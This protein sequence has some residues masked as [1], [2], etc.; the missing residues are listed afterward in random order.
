MHRLLAAL[1]L[2]SPRDGISKGPIL[3]TLTALALP[4]ALSLACA[5]EP[6]LTPVYTFRAGPRRLGVYP[7]LEVSGHGLV[8]RAFQTDG[9]VRASPVAAGGVLLFGSG[10]GNFYAVEATGGRERWR[11]TAGSAILSSAAVAGDLVFFGDRANGFYAL[12]RDSG[13]LR[14]RVE[15]GE[16]RAFEWGHE[17]WDYYTS[18]PVLADGAV[19]V[20][21][22]D[23]NLYAL[24][25][26]SGEERWRYQTGGRIRSSPAA[27]DGRVYVG[28]ADGVLYAIEVETGRLAW[29]FETWGAG[30]SS[31]DFGYD[32]KTIQSSPAVADGAVF[33]GSRDGK[34]YAVDAAT[35]RERW[36]HDNGSPWVV[37]SPAVADGR[38]YVGSSDGLFVHALDAATGEEI[39]RL[40]TG[41]RVFSSPAVS[42]DRLY[43]GHHGRRLLSIER[44]SGELAWEL[45][46]GAAIMSSPI[47][48]DGRIYVGADDGRLYAVDAVAGTP[49]RLAVYWDEERIAWNTLASHEAVRDYFDVRGYEVV[50]RDA[51]LELMRAQVEGG[52]RSVVV[53]AMDDL[54]AGVAPEASDTVLARRYLEAGG[55]IVWLGLPPLLFIRN[56]EGRVTGFD[57][58]RP[59]A[60]LGVSHESYNTDRIPA[61]PTEEGRLWGLDGWWVAN[62][63]VD[64]ASVTP[65]ALDEN[66]KA[67]AWARSYDGPPGSGFVQ[68]WNSHR[69]IDPAYYAWI[70]AVAEAG[71]TRSLP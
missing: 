60:L 47:I 39:W 69:P 53:F 58:S 64:P 68:V 5:P 63:G 28:S 9:P 70:A 66:G 4:A 13:R 56:G 36:R 40:S 67:A 18:S 2:R 12:D 34:L 26:L 61:Y 43:L 44:A 3:A 42:G 19:I 21:S 41:A 11:F 50:D 23:G 62:T 6:E 71:V 45:P 24:D 22:G 46:L 57:R 59:G 55:K 25:A 1:R 51:L 49:P 65:L 7:S 8:R 14:W 30:Q 17:G 20:G 52:G 27:A 37:G 15:T 54:P 16:D 10:D 38:V 33:F 31:A 48:H 35:G 32:R 29:R